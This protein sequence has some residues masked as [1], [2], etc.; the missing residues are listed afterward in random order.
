MFSLEVLFYV[1]LGFFG[2]VFSGGCALVKFLL[3]FIVPFFFFLCVPALFRVG[4]ITGSNS[5]KHVTRK[6]TRITVCGG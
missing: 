1:F 2:V 4:I 5:A 6:V 3:L